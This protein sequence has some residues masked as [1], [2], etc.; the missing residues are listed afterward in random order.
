MYPVIW[1]TLSEP[2]VSFSWFII[3]V[4]ITKLPKQPYYLML[5]ALTDI[6]RGEEF[7]I[8][9]NPKETQGKNKKNKSKIPA[10]AEECKCGSK[11]WCRGW[12]KF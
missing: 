12:V 1:D 3:R 11:E 10:G 8:D 7:T 9:Y 4:L 6:P 5:V 2:N